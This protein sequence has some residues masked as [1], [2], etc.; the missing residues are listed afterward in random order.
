MKASDKAKELVNKYLQLHDGR[1]I[2]AK[3]CALICV[4][5]IIN[6]GCTLPSQTAYGDNEESVKYW[7]EVRTEIEKL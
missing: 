7:Q 4:D 2:I 1:V 3:Q 5:E 6:S